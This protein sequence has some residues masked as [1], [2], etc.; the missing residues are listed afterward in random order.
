MSEVNWNWAIEIF[1]YSDWY[2]LFK[3]FDK[4]YKNGYYYFVDFG[5]S[6]ITVTPE[7]NVVIGMEKV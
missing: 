7:G 2:D 1:K 4:W 6:V 5:G 3:V